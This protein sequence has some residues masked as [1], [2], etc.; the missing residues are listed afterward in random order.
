MALATT[1]LPVPVSP[2]IRTE[3]A[4][5]ATMPIRFLSSLMGADCPEINLSITCIFKKTGPL[6][7]LSTI[8]QTRPPVCHV[9][10]L[11]V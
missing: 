4:D 5:G 11:I 7:T 1:S 2:C 10:E 9:F 6:N 8:R 3:L